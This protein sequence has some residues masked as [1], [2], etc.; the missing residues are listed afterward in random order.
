[1]ALKAKVL[2]CGELPGRH[3]ST[4]SVLNNRSMCGLC[5]NFFRDLRVCHRPCSFDL[6]LFG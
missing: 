5:I 1:M 2:F 4:G 6:W 3:D